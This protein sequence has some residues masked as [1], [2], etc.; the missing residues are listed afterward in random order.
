MTKID[1]QVDEK[2]KIL[3]GLEK[4]FEKLLEYKKL[5]NSELIVMRN[6]KIVRLKADDLMLSPKNKSKQ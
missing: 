5:K 2:D 6:N 4:A 3:K 1:S